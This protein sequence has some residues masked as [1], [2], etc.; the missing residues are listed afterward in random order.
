MQ[1]AVAVWWLSKSR[2]VDPAS[3]SCEGQKTGSVP[4][5]VTLELSN[6]TQAS[7]QNVEEVAS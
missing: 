3:L 2:G 7:A 1:N 4:I 6:Y 5:A